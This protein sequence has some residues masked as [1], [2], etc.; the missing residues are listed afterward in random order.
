MSQAL[1]DHLAFTRAPDA[2]GTVQI[3]QPTIPLKPSRSSQSVQWLQQTARVV[4]CDNHQVHLTLSAD[5]SNCQHCP[6]PNGCGAT[7]IG[8]LWSRR[9][10]PLIVPRDR[11]PA[12]LQTDDRF[13]VSI[14]AAWLQKAV[15]LLYALPLGGLVGGAILGAWLGDTFFFAQATEPTSILTGLLGLSTGLAYVRWFMSPT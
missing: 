11:F 3:D 5:S 12:A 9:H 2:V 13:M 6:Q 14:D 10:Y 8:R 7:L 15:G 1:I 4:Y